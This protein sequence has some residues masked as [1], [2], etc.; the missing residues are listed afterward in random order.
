MEENSLTLHRRWRDSRDP[1]TPPRSQSSLGVAQDDSDRIFCRTTELLKS[2]LTHYRRRSQS[3]WPT[4][5]KNHRF[6]RSSLARR[7]VSIRR[8]TRLALMQTLPEL[9]QRWPLRDFPDLSQQIIRE[10]HAGHGRARLQGAMQSIRH[11][12]EGESLCF[13][14]LLLFAAWL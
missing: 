2:K 4:Y 14:G 1:S 3:A 13:V 5:Q 10:R 12:A 8:R 6:S 11:A 7:A 9:R